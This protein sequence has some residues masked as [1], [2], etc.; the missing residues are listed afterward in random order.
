M[1]GIR[2]I[3]SLSIMKAVE[4]EKLLINREVEFLEFTSGFSFGPSSSFFNII[5][6]LVTTSNVSKA[7]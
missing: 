6:G 7:S 5:C 2:E 3:E 1:E 4:N